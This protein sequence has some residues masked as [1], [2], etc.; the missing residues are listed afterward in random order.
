VGDLIKNFK[1]VFV[2]ELNL[3]QL[4]MI[5]NSKFHCKAKGYNK[6]QGLPFK[7]SELVEAI[8]NELN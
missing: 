1:K 3:G 6:V 4:L 7:I 8:K 2:P 5:I